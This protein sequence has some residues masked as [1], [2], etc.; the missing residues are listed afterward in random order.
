[1]RASS[2]PTRRPPVI[3]TTLPGE[4]AVGRIC[5][6]LVISDAFPDDVGDAGA[7]VDRAGQHEQKVA[8]PI[9]VDEHRSGDVLAGFLRELDDQ[10]LG[11]PADGACQV[12]LGG[13]RPPRRAG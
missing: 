3:R 9:Q 10:P 1:M 6:R 13:R 2:P 4:L 5:V 8:E 11:A 7:V 12:E